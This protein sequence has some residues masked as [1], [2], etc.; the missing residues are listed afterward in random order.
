MPGIPNV[1]HGYSP[2]AWN[3]TAEEGMSGE[4]GEYIYTVSKI[5]LDSGEP[6]VSVSSRGPQGLV[7]VRSK[8]KEGEYYGI[9]GKI[10]WISGK[11]SDVGEKMAKEREEG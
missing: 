9:T 5:G 6:R 3:N 1:H 10:G 2:Q 11:G 4:G 8:G 7:W